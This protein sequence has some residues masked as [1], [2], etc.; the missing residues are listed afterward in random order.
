VPRTGQPAARRVAA[1]ER[2]LAVLDAV[3]AAPDEIGTNELA[4]R[5]GLNASTVSR[6][7]ASLV[8]AGLVDHDADSGRYRLGVRMIGLGNA[9]LA[10]LD[11]RALARP[12]LEALV[13]ETGETATLSMSGEPDA[14]TVDFVQSPSSVQSVATV[15]RPSIAH[16]TATG[17]VLLAFGRDHLPRGPLRAF[18]ERTITKRPA[19]RR[20]LER[21]RKRG[22]ADAV[23]ER[24]VDL[25]AIA[26][27]V[28]DAADELAAIVGLQG[29][30]S[31]FD[32]G[33]RDAALGL[34]LL[35]AQKL[36]RALGA[37]G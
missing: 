9:V 21:V 37:G 29:P 16:A 13:E 24:E 23:G 22:Y 27:P 28:F 7:L 31:R 1:V 3:A 20:E 2:A 5:T 35:H 17:K 32:R 11:L 12:H 6:L 18:T 36:S 34:L 19:L 26:A 33:A 4:R 30:S 10:R 15:G 14:I 25:S 8:A